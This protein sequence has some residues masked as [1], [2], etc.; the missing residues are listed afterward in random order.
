M[1][2]WL[3]TDGLGGFAMGTADGIRTRRYHAI[4]LVAT[5]PPDG[6]M[7][8]VAD[9]EVFVETADGRFALSSHCYRGD[10]VFPDGAQHL[11][12]FT[13]RPWPR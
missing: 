11:T 9:L 3:E 13:H 10:V 4:L 7:V 5:R 12:A 6:R 8:L 2:E 1:T